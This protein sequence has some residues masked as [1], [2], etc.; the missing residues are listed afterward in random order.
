V[1]DTDRYTVISVDGHAGADMHGYKPYLASRWHDEFD[2]WADAYVN[3]YADLLAKTA[4][5]NWDSARR[6]EE[7]ESQGVVAEVLFPNTIP[8]FFAQSNLTALEPTGEDYERRLAG[9]RAHNRWLADFCAAAPG[10]RAGCAQV[11][12]N[13]LDDTLAE[14]AWA[15][16]NMH[17]CGGI[18]MPNVP[19]NSSL[20]PLWDPHYEPLWE[21]CEARDVVINIHSGSGLP[22]FG[23]HEAARAIMLIELAWYAHRVVWHLIF[24]G[25][26]ERH[27][28]LR[29]VLTEQGTSWVPRGLDT[30]DWFHRRMTHGS[31][32]E[33]VFFGAVAKQMSLTPTEYFQRNFW[34][35]ASFLRPSESALRYD[36]GIDRIMWGADYPHSEGTYPYTTEALRAAFAGVP[37]EETKMMLETN[38]AGVYPFDLPALR[39]VGDRIGPTVAD[40]QVPLD[41][42]DYPADSTCNA[43]DQEQV[44][45]AW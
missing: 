39:A 14:V 21:L 43:F 38:A 8:P 32:A 10:R 7:T 17:V 29:I 37:P 34:V 42:V 40:V 19:P 26:L 3:P 30:L 22:D 11:F 12:L 31:A 33:A 24:G 35:G 13:D 44:I 1:H 28:A 15:A 6:I 18:L 5:R 27:P 36:V 20:L 4:Y 16:D 25:V 23:T 45:K 2:A 9:I 41:P